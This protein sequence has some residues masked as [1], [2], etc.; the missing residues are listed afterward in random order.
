MGNTE[1]LSKFSIAETKTFQK[2]I[3]SRQYRNYYEKIKEVIYPQLKENPYLGNNI[4][5]LK[6]E[7]SNIFRYRIGDYR[8]FYTIDPEKRIIFIMDFE[9]RKDAYR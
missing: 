3:E 9:N 5:R 2:K 4:K 1:L 7:L 6:G 8:L